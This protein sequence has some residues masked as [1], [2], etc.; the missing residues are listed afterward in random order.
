M[1]MWLTSV[2]MLHSTSH[3]FINSIDLQSKRSFDFDTL[4]MTFRQ[5]FQVVDECFQIGP[6]IREEE[7]GKVFM[8]IKFLAERIRYAS[9][10]DTARTQ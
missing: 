6:A 7:T 1:Q 8:S 9:S 4:D 10:Y 5:L 3:F 2:Y